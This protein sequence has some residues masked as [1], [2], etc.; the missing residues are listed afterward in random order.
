MKICVYTLGC[1]VNRYESGALLRQLREQGHTVTDKLEPCDKF[2]VNTCAVTAEAERK[3]RNI[4]AKI[5]AV[6]PNAEIFAIGCASQHKPE[7]FTGKANVAAAAGTA[8]KNDVRRLLSLRG[9]SL[10]PL[11]AAFEDAPGKNAHTRAYVKVQDG[12]DNFCSYC[13][14]PYLRGRARSRDAGAV[15]A[16]IESLLAGGA[17]EIVLTGINLSAY[18][19]AEGR[20]LAWL[21]GRLSGY[22]VRIRLGSLETASAG[23]ELLGALKG[24]KKFCPHFH[25]SLQAGSDKVLR[26]MNRRYTAEEFLLSV[27]G[28]RRAFPAAAVT[29]DVICGYPTETEADFLETVRVA[30]LAEFA[31]I[32]VFPYSPRPG[33]P[34]ADLKPLP[35]AGVKRRAAELKGLKAELRAA[36]TEKNRGKELYLLT[37]TKEKGLLSGYTENYL[38]AYI[39]GGR[40]NEVY[41]IRALQAYADGVKA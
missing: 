39:A 33:T 24:L 30:R 9:A 16:E 6:S 3:S 14:V 27:E 26:D 34:A 13:I 35:P 21:I 25:L 22:D 19:A 28:I 1:K 11:P 23:E 37:E 7:N 12:C 8:G 41:K 5:R 17:K 2:I 20:S 15:R 4:L 40:E 36:F 31:D 18:G 38:K 10:L 32:H 29:T